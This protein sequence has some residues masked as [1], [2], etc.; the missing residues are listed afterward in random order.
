VEA[1]AGLT[2]EAAGAIAVEAAGAP[3]IEGLRVASVEDGV[4]MVEDND[5]APA[6]MRGDPYWVVCEEHE[7]G[8]V[9]AFRVRLDFETRPR[10]GRSERPPTAPARWRRYRCCQAPDDQPGAEGPASPAR[11]R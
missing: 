5:E 9:P 10:S 7:R 6:G 3:A 4:W 1:V 2:A 8:A 11:R